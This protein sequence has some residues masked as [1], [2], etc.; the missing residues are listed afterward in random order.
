MAQTKAQNNHNT[1]SNRRF[2]IGLTRAFAGAIL[3]VFPM[4]MTM[5]MWTLGFAVERYRLAFFI[6]LSIPLLIGLSYF[7]GFEETSNLTDDLTDAFVAYAVG[8]VTSAVLLF[9]FGILSFDMSADEI[10]GK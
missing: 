4:I 3:F 9:L 5:E 10:I 1:G 7:I 8:F 6:F 2:L